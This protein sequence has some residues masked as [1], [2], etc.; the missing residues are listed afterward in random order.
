MNVL[1]FTSFQDKDRVQRIDSLAGTLTNGWKLTVHWKQMLFNYVN[2]PDGTTEEEFLDWWETEKPHHIKHFV[3]FV[4][5][6]GLAALI[7]SVNEGG[8]K[9]ILFMDDNTT[10]E[11]LC[12]VTGI[13]INHTNKLIEVLIQ[14]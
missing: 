10:V 9:H 6:F 14:V 11:G 1:E 13:E 2:L 7:A 8:E 5:T 12:L 4:V 3:D